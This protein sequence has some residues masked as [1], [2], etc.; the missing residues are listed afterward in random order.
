MRIRTTKTG[1]FSTAV[2]VVRYE[3]GKTIILK[4]I[5]SA[6]NPSEVSHLMEVAREWIESFTHQQ[7]FFRKE[8]TFDPLFTKYRYLGFRYNFLYE[9][10]SRVFK[11]FGFEMFGDKLLLDLVLIRIVE[12]SSKLRSQKLLSELF[13]ISYDLTS[14]YKSL[15]GMASLKDK[16]EESLV[17]FAR[18]NLSFDFSF[19]LYDVTTLYFESFTNDEFRK[20][21][22]SKDNKAN[23]PQIVIGLLVNRDGFPLS[24]NVFPGNKFEGHTLI[25]VI[26]ALKDKYRISTLSVV[27]DAAMLSEDNLK[28][29]KQANLSYI[30]GARLG[31]IS[32]N[33]V[34]RINQKLNMVSSATVRLSVNDGFLICDFS[35]KRYAKDKSDTEKQIA[36]ARNIL[37]GKINPKRLKFLT[38]EKTGYVLNEKL[39]ERTKLLWGIKGY[40]T[41]LSLPDQLIIDR[42]HDLWQVEKSFRITKSDLLMRPVYHFKKEA[43]VAHILICVMALAVAK[44][45]ELRSGKS[46]K[47]IIESFKRIT[48]ARI[49]N[50]A[51]GEEAL[52]RVEIPKEVKLLLKD[53]GVTY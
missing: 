53:I 11:L 15:K 45:M 41:D 24:F 49:L 33:T 32:L 29:L 44:F 4:H 36:K 20:C 34:K 7:T 26:T 48:D 3:R 12:P 37:D 31:Y 8:P 18:K 51:S 47:V 2:Q 30:V 39:I 52:W 17:N 22:F 35:S 38:T 9:T 50:P 19:V 14:I 16:V 1:S 6:K 13:G 27:A 40:C 28:A 21:G 10:L 43:I 25:P 42:Y 5:G 46:I 23:Q